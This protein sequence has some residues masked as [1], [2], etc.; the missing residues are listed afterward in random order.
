MEKKTTVYCKTL[1]DDVVPSTMKQ[2]EK[3]FE[4][5]KHHELY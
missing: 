3:N 1:T 4:K 2:S 5:L